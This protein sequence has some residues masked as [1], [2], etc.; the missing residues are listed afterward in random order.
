MALGVFGVIEKICGAIWPEFVPVAHKK[1]LFLH[2]EFNRV[3]HDN[4]S[5]V[6]S[7]AH[8]LRQ[9]LRV[10]AH[11]EQNPNFTPIAIS[12][13]YSV[14]V[15]VFLKVQL[16]GLEMLLAWGDVLSLTESCREGALLR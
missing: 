5:P 4:P 9:C 8:T 6:H 13:I 14:P 7:V 1:Q 15:P 12:I 11:R 3:A 10:C 2:I 16:C